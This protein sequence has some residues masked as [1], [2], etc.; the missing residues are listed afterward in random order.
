MSYYF[1]LSFQMKKVSKQYSI[2]YIYYKLNAVKSLYNNK[3]LSRVFIIYK[4]CY[5]LFQ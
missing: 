2:V 3:G 5:M 1:F 4:I